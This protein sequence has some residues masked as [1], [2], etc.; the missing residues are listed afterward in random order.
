MKSVIMFKALLINPPRDNVVH[1]DC[2]DF[3]D[4]G[5]ISSFP[6]IGLM[7]LAQGLRDKIPE[8]EVSILDSVAEGLN[9]AEIGDQVSKRSPDVIG[10]TAT[11]YTFYDV[12]ET[13]KTIK[14]VK[15]NIPIVVGG[16]HMYI[17]AHE[18]MVHECFDYGV[19]GDGEEVFAG[20]CMA[21]SRM[22]PVK[23]QNGLLMRKNG[24]VI[25]S[26][27]AEIRNLDDIEIPAIDLI[28]PF[29]YYSTLGKGKAIG[30]ICTS[31]GCPYNCTYCQV[32]RRK[33]RMRAIKNIIREIE[34]YINKGIDDYL[35]FDDLFNITKKRVIEFCESILERKLKITWM[36][37][38]RVDQI[39]EEVMKL[40]YR[41]GCRNVSVGIEDSTNEGL[42][43]IKKEITIKQAYAA[44]RA[45][46]KNNIKCSTNW[47]IGFPHHKRRSDLD[48][49]LDM[50]IKINGD[51]AQFS[52]LQCLPGTELWDQA[53]SEGGIDPSA[54][55]NY[56]LEPKK[57]FFPPIWEK[58]F[59]KEELY[60]FYSAAY[61]RYY[62]RPEMLLREAL[63]IRSWAEVNNKVRS[64]MR[65]FLI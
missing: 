26:D 42:K 43:A 52:I 35:F 51:Y 46:R 30:T 3:V 15:P 6:P 4:L 31:R 49:L 27:V 60:E 13:A 38:G 8:I 40:A 22:V 47:I 21:I 9:H 45:I 23:P 61:R 56:V 29:K 41:A 36:F 48:E 58:H 37:R 24:S 12:W 28:D 2:P 11:T 39:D 63:S 59:R 10:V 33:Y 1:L 54:W 14:K 65:V 44:V 7:Y 25:G 62:L 57:K 18:T 53:V 17:L 64:F 32:P 50:A 34:F 20:L 16:P 19:I 55:R 5:S